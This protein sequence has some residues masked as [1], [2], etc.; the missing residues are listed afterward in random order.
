MTQAAP[1]M[2]EVRADTIRALTRA[3]AYQRKSNARVD[4]AGFLAQVLAATATNV[5]GLERLPSGRPGSWEAS[6]VEALLL[7]T[8]GDDWVTWRTFRT[9][10]LVIPLNVAELI[11]GRDHPGLLSLDDALEAVGLRY[12]SAGDDEEA[13][14]AWHAQVEALIS[15]YR[16]E[17]RA[18]ANRLVIAA[19]AGEVLDLSCRVEVNVD[20]DPTSTRY[21]N[22]GIVNP[23]EFETEDLTLSIWEAAH[24]SVSL[25]NVD[26]LITALVR[27]STA[28]EG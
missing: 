25:P 1:T 9:E 28:G 11:Q 2:D 3:A 13:Q 27:R 8:V 18:Y 12:E 21:D 6:H 24:D 22:S 26:I 20:C 17:Y 14:N 7:G 23:F 10:P 19:K 5:G 16:S 15:R 4:F